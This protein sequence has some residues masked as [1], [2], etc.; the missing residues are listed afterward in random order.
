MGVVDSSPRLADNRS[1][2]RL[3]ATP[4][5][6]ATSIYSWLLWGDSEETSGVISVSDLLFV[7]S[8]CYYMIAYSSFSTAQFTGNSGYC[9][10]LF[11]PFRSPAKRVIVKLTPGATLLLA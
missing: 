9:F 3:A 6:S 2:I 11:P 1:S 4:N 7:L 5:K 8:T 10:T